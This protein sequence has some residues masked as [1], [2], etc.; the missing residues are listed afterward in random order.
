MRTVIGV[1]GG[2]TADAVTTANARA[3]GEVIAER[4]WALLNGCQGVATVDQRNHRPGPR[5]TTRVPSGAL[6]SGP[7]R[8]R[9]GGRR[10]GRGLSI[11]I[12]AV[13]LSG[14]IYGGWL[15]WT[16]P[17][18][19]SISATP[20]DAVISSCEC[21]ATGALELAGLKPGT[22][23]VTVQRA[24][25]RPLA[26][27][28][29]VKR[30]GENSLDLA[31]QP[32]PQGLS[33]SATPDTA[34]C[35]VVDAAG[36]QVTAGTG[37]IAATLPAGVYTI[38]ISSAGKN[39]FS[40]EIYLDRATALNVRLDPEGQ[41]VHSLGMLECA[42]A[43]KGI[44]FTP[45][46]REA[47]TSILNG[48]P[49]IEI[50]D[51]KTLALIGE[52]DIGRFGAV[53]IAFSPDG[54]RA[55]ASQMETAKVFEIDVKTRKVLREL[56]TE[57]AWTKVVAVSPDGATLYAANWSGDD[58]SEIDLVSGTLRRRIPVADTPRGLWPTP[59]GTQL[60]VAGFGGGELE[61]VDLASGK[62]TQVFDSNGALRHLVGDPANGVLYASDMAKD[63]VWAFDLKSERTSKFCDTDAKPNTID[64][65]P[66]G[67]V[68][69]VSCRGENNPKSYYI[70]GFEWGTILL[71]DTNSATPLDAIVGGNQCTA[72][73]VSDDGTML[74]FSD[75]LDDRLQ[76]FQVP[77]HETLA[78]GDGGRWDEHFEDL[79]K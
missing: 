65:S 17:V 79:R 4:G 2:G 64:L 44:V 54:T 49:S 75:F 25:Y 37:S 53:E 15:V 61:R 30:F 51:A 52:I 50:F 5:P 20:A 48:P 62:V 14:A 34:A 69:F 56:A 58:V 59:D 41:L 28:L 22:Y 68:L 76:L 57:S 31:M 10:R 19:A 73:D 43:P 42:G 1:M 72:L 8:R 12:A 27:E 40:R 33:V 18:T 70:P 23:A 66:D 13:V 6:Q 39:P 38:E 63:C 71:F 74:A 9:G 32:L 24:G 55:F 21:T 7:R 36:T 67:K 46:G 47:W 77:P 3:L 45:D 78:A 35:R 29:T 26:A 16:R 11:A 60:Y